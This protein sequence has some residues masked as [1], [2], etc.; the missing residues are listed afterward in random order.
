[1]RRVAIRVYR[2][3]GLI[4]EGNLRDVSAYAGNTQIQKAHGVFECFSE[5]SERR[6]SRGNGAYIRGIKQ[7]LQLILFRRPRRGA[8]HEGWGND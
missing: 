1:M 5:A 8:I 7:L 3:H 6:R 2:G 4:C